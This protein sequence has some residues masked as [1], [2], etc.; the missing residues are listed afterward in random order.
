MNYIPKNGTCPFWLWNGKMNK[1]ELSRQ[2]KLAKEGGVAGLT[3]HARV[4][5]E[6]PY[7]SD[8][9]ME[10]TRFVCE[11]AQRAGLKIWLYDEQGFPSGD[12]GGMIPA[13]GENFQQKTLLFI[14]VSAK[15]AREFNDVI[16]VF[17]KK[18]PAQMVDPAQ[19]PD[20]EKVI[21]FRRIVFPNHPDLLY[22]ET[23]KEFIKITHEKYYAALRDFFEQGVITAV[24]TDDNHYLFPPGPLL[25][26]MDDLEESFSAAYGYSILDNLSAMVENIPGAEKVRLDYHAHM[27]TAFNERFMKVM[28]EWCADHNVA[29]LGHLSGDEGPMQLSITRFGDP[30][31]YMKYFRIPGLDDFLL[32]DLDCRQMVSPINRVPG[33]GGLNRAD[34]FPVIVGAKQASSVASQLGEGLCM[35]EVLASSGW[36]VTMESVMNHLRFLNILGVNIFVPHD[37]SY[38]SGKVAKRD[39]P[40][41]YFFQQPYYQRNEEIFRSM[42][43]SLKWCLRGKGYAETLVIHPIHSAQAAFDGEELDEPGHYRCNQS[44]GQPSSGEVT[45]SLSALCLQ[46]MRHHVSFEFGYESMIREYA[47]VEENRFRIGNAAYQAVILPNMA[48]V[49]ADLAA[50]LRR[51]DEA[52]GRVIYFCRRPDIV[53]GEKGRG[54]LLPAGELIPCIEEEKFPALSPD[55]DFTAE[56]GATSTVATAVRIVDGKKEYMLHNCN[57]EETVLH[58]LLSGYHCV[59]PVSGAVFP[60]PEKCPLEP[61]AM[62]HLIPAERAPVSGTVPSIFRC[63]KSETVSWK[64]EWRIKADRKNVYR[65]DEATSF[66]SR[67]SDFAAK[68]FELLPGFIP[69][70]NSF[71]LESQPDSL[72]L[73]VEPA[74]Y[75]TVKVNGVDILDRPKQVHDASPDLYCIE[76]A[77]L[78]QPGRNTYAFTRKEKRPEFIYLIGDFSV[79]ESGELPVLKPA[80]P[81]TFGDISRQGMPFYWGCVEY[82]S[83]WDAEIIPGKQYRIE[84]PSPVTGAVGLRINGV[85]LPMRPCPPWRYDVTDCIRPGGNEVTMIYYGTAQNFLGPRRVT[86]QKAHFTGWYPERDGEL[87]DM[88]QGIPAEPVI[89]IVD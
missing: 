25:A 42:N 18:D 70:F 80:P 16:R 64:N 85:D 26:Y 62:I 59:D 52:G 38:T 14:E 31:T 67:K 32:M 1:A 77:D 5:N 55:L 43:N 20:D 81:L 63:G 79:D 10:L 35:S 36:G 71:I 4:G 19:L 84:I 56:N 33:G 24:F 48:S 39:H 3:L 27:A 23:G 83:E 28:H 21:C 44:S 45:D 65:W 73:A 22:P 37:Y 50:L 7:L 41:S 47:S 15:K 17:S 58:I 9:W 8:E 87:F 46:L 75:E 69:Y 68:E 53:N 29:L 51:F 88:P 54:D 66:Y 11:E 76:I 72:L 13:L 89:R 86:D 82:T 74:L 78:V 49:S 12:A 6:I 61:Y 40:A 57:S 60:L 2:V 30:G 34:G